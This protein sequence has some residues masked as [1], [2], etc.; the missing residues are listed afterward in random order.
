MNHH[1]ALGVDARQIRAK[2]SICGLLKA[3]G[4]HREVMVS[5]RHLP[6]YQNPATA[7]TRRAV[8]HTQNLG[9]TGTACPPRISRTT[10]SLNSGVYLPLACPSFLLLTFSRQLLNL[11]ISQ[12]PP[13]KPVA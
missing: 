2:A 5:S 12:I 10:S 6:R 11:N 13:A 7:S 8:A 1:R 4:I 9:R 3:T